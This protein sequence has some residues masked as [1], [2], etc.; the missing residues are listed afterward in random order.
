VTGCRERGKRI[1]FSGIRRPHKETKPAKIDVSVQHLDGVARPRQKEKARKKTIDCIHV[2]RSQKY[3]VLQWGLKRKTWV[4]DRTEERVGTSVVGMLLLS[5]KKFKNN[6]MRMKKMGAGDQDRGGRTANGEK[7]ES[8]MTIRNLLRHNPSQEDPFHQSFME[9][10]PLAK[11]EKW[12]WR[13]TRKR[14]RNLL[15]IFRKFNKKGIHS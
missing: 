5:P 2:K 1:P 10:S 12:P 11:R 13:R 4:R 3:L 14:L 7:E 9:K 15:N 8:K 6:S